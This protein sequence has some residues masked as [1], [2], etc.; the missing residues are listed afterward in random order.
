M[1]SMPIS[2]QVRNGF[3]WVYEKYI[4]NAGADIQVSYRQAEAEAWEKQRGHRFRIAM[5]LQPR[6]FALAPL[7][8]WRSGG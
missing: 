1:E 7:G 4:G 2:S 5:I 3:A 6:A 8:S